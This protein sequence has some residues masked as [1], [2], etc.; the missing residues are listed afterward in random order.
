[1]SSAMN[2]NPANAGSGVYPRLGEKRQGDGDGKAPDI[3][4]RVI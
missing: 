2:S 1:M 4:L 3:L